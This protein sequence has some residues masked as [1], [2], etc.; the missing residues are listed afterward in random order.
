MCFLYGMQCFACV[1][2]HRWMYDLGTYTVNNSS[3]F[4][5]FR[6]SLLG[7]I[8]GL[9]GSSLKP[10]LYQLHTC[11]IFQEMGVEDI[12]FCLFCNSSFKF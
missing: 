7:V 5:S 9:N 8:Q 4:S 12:D 11:V 10:L 1:Q 3:A 6:C 2:V